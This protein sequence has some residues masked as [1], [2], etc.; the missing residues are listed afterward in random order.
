MKKKLQFKQ[1]M[2]IITATLISVVFVCLIFLHSNFS[3]AAPATIQLKS[4]DGVI[5]Y[6][7]GE[8][9]TYDKE[10]KTYGVTKNSDVTIHVINDYMIADQDDK[11]KMIIV[12]TIEDGVATEYRSSNIQTITFSAQVDTAYSVSTHS[13]AITP[14]DFGKSISSPYTLYNSSDF[15][16]LYD[17]L[18]AGSVTAFTNNE[19]YKNTFHSD[20]IDKL[21][22][23]YYKV[24]DNLVIE[25]N[26]FYGLKDFGG[27]FDFNNHS[28]TISVNNTNYS[29][30]SSNAT[31]NAGLFSS[32]TGSNTNPVVIRNGSFRGSIALSNDS[33]S[34]YSNI[35]LGGIAGSSSGVVI[36]DS[37]SV[38]LSL[39]VNDN[40]NI[41]I[42]G[43][44]GVSSTPI[45]DYYNLVNNGIYSSLQADTHKAASSVTIGG[46]AGTYSNAYIYNYTDNSYNKNI[47][48][49]SS[50]TSTGNVYAGGFI[51]SLSNSS[52]SNKYIKGITLKPRGEYVISSSINN[53]SSSTASSKVISAGV[54][55]NISASNALYFDDIYFERNEDATVLDNFNITAK[56]TSATSY[57]N[58]Y[59]GGL[60]G[61]VP[62]SNVYFNEYRKDNTETV[63]LFTGNLTVEAIQNGYNEA[64]A[65]G[66]FAY[67][68]FQQSNDGLLNFTLTPNYDGVANDPFVTILASQSASSKQ[69]D[70]ENMQ[71]VVAGYYSSVLPTDYKLTNFTLSINNSTVTALRDV[72]SKSI[73]NV[74]A[75]GLA[76]SAECSSANSAYYFKDITLNLVD[77]SINSLGLSFDSNSDGNGSY[78]V[79]NF[80]NNMAAGGFIAHMK[81]YDATNIFTVTI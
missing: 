42:G 31:L 81:N 2:A 9:V 6:V 36:Y 7:T 33:G 15:L 13:R 49:N 27:V 40:A 34:G 11:N 77:S 10:T 68:A 28:L 56:N 63:T 75:G 72:G 69:Y 26:E 1:I 18:Q 52:G 67:N 29:T 19:I 46:F 39:T 70:T 21:K 24:M 57:G 71:D 74:F 32:L 47:I 80:D 5:Y 73:G 17:I 4:G 48:A 22:V 50:D 30:T 79:R 45:Q 66:M 61:Y 37:L 41:N 53:T 20:S 23:G 60:Y 38:G 76:G 65:G 8:N 12:S 62:S 55:A 44:F 59:A 25:R 3:Y 64:F 78:V 51:G 35:N 54:I 14:T 16:L 58:V 43:F